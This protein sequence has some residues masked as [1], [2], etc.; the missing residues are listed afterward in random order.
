MSDI[1]DQNHIFPEPDIDHKKNNYRPVM[2]DDNSVLE[3][4]HLAP[5]K[6]IIPNQNVS[7]KGVIKDISNT[8]LEALVKIKEEE[9]RTHSTGKII[10]QNTQLM[11]NINSQTKTESIK[12][13]I[14]FEK[15]TNFFDSNLGKFLK[16]FW[17]LVTLIS[18]LAL[19]AIYFGVINYL[20]NNKSVP[21]ATK[22]ELSI[23]GPQK[24]P[25]SAL[26]T[27]TIKIDNKD[28]VDLKNISI[29]MNYDRDF[30]VSKVYG[31]IKTQSDTNKIFKL[32]KLGKGQQ[33]IFNIEGKLE[34]QV[35][36]ETKMSAIMRFMIDGVEDNKQKVQEKQS[37]EFV[38]KVEKSVVR[39][40]ISADAR[41]PVE[42]EQEI[43]VDFT[44]QSGK[45]LNNFKLKMNYPEVGTN[46]VYLSSVL[47]MPGRT[48][49][50]LPTVGD[51]T[52]NVTSLKNGE[53][54]KL[55]IKAK[56]KGQPQDKLN[57]IAELK[58]NDN[59]ELLNKADKEIIIVDKAITARP[60][61]DLD[62]LLIENA[63]IPFKIVVKNNYN[64]DLKNVKVIASFIDNADL[65]DKDSLE[66][67]TGQ[68]ILNKLG[69]EVTF[70]GAG[71][72]QLQ[73]LGP[74]GEVSLEFRFRIKPISAFTTSTFSQDN[75]FIQPKVTVT[76]DNFES[77]SET[78]DIKRAKG[79]P[80]VKQT[81]Q[82]VQ[83]GTKKIARVTWE[84]K[85]RF[86]NLRDFKLRSRTPLPGITAW[87]QDSITPPVQSSRITYNKDTGEVLWNPG[88]VK[89]YTGYNG[90]ELKVTFTITNE[91]DSKINFLDTPTFTAIDTLNEGYEFNQI[92]SPLIEGSQ[93]G[94]Q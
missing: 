55:I 27:W 15:K 93:I 66:G 52:W 7:F 78:G 16:R 26:K 61:L 47:V 89:A 51:H 50:V 90:Q 46:F 4:E 92:N 63:I 58:S 43:K 69:K 77:Q 14:S 59:D 67:E 34:A 5:E 70:T 56:L 35:D 32:D 30:K 65:I 10:E 39:I 72:T 60:S 94:Y 76:G 20:E 11:E 88:D 13:I 48:N 8:N 54:G 29:D 83:D 31:D 68:P 23:E 38:T 71:L 74:K 57:F 79:G 9:Y 6:I 22:V 44:N 80:E 2:A 41:V 28:S 37:K 42:S 85:N 91:T 3:I 25:K 40:D 1:K 45:D 87:K 53:S 17:W 81:F 21:I 64:S 33:K 49:Q 19:A 12:N 73:Q 84:V 86:S 36:I 24:A 18:I 82:I 75:F 62:G